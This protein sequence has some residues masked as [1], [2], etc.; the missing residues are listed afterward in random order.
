MGKK[1]SSLFSFA[2]SLLKQGDKRKHFAYS[3][4]IAGIGTAIAKLYDS[5]VFEAF[6]IGFGIAITIGIVKEYLDSTDPSR[7]T[8]DINDIYADFGGATLGSL[9]TM[10]LW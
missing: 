2:S 10:L 6:Y 3:A 8:E 7:H 5:N 9:L 1:N 4:I